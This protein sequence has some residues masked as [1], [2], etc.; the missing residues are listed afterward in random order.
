MRGGLITAIKLVPGVINMEAVRTIEDIHIIRDV[1]RDGL[2]DHP[3]YLGS[4]YRSREEPTLTRY[5]AL[6]AVGRYICAAE[7]HIRAKEGRITDK[8]R[9][10]IRSMVI[11]GYPLE[12]KAENDVLILVRRARDLVEVVER[13]G[14]IV[15]CMFRAL[16]L[17][18]DLKDKIRDRAFEIVEALGYTDKYL[19]VSELICQHGLRTKIDDC[20]E[21]ATSRIAETFKVTP[22]MR[23][24]AKTTKERKLR[25]L[26][27]RRSQ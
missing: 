19:T 1:W 6:Y 5:A 10:K 8:L 11:Q 2:I 4:I 18:I 22:A 21:L 14:I 7:A 15:L 26:L 23:K 27:K 17:Y 9:R 12:T 13:R 24:E 20:L 25:K 3:E 16:M